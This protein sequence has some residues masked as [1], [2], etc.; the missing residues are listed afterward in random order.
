MCTDKFFADNVTG[1]RIVKVDKLDLE[2]ISLSFKE[3]Y[4]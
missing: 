1:I 4:E 3:I 2:K